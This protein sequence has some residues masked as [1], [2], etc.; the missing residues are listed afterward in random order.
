MYK[1]FRFLQLMNSDQ[2]WCVNLGCVVRLAACL[3]NIDV[4]QIPFRP[5]IK[6]KP[7]YKWFEFMRKH[8]T[9]SCEKQVKFNWDIIVWDSL[10]A[11]LMNNTITP[12]DWT[13]DIIHN[14]LLIL[15]AFIVS[16]IY[17]TFMCYRPFWNVLF[18][19]V[20]CTQIQQQ[21]Q[22][23]S[24]CNPALF[25]VCTLYTVTEVMHWYNINIL[26][27]CLFSEGSF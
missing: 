15:S 1:R 20:I 23:C 10:N 18:T 12:I 6:T 14:A 2:I 25:G 3:S 7:A 11:Q 13:S 24:Y 5:F 26:Y 4:N 21:Y 8:H 27:C 22:L 16:Y 19:N 9:F 17:K